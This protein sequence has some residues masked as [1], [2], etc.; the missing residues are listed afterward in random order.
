MA[1]PT[2]DRRE[3]EPTIDDLIRLARIDFGI[4]VALVF[5]LLHGG[6]NMVPASYIN[7]IVEALMR[8]TTGGKRRLIFNLPP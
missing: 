5:P 4:L 8:T 7:L 3:G 1:H 2:N 6:K